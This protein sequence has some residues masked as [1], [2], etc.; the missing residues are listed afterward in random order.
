MT[1][2][3]PVCGKNHGSETVVIWGIEVKTCP[4]LPLNF[5]HEDREFESGPPGAL[6]KLPRQLSDD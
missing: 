6:H 4:T 2:P 5:F 1:E 3:C